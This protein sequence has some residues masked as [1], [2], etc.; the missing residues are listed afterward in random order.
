VFGSLGDLA[1]LMQ[2]AK[3]LGGKLGTLADE[4]REQRVE[5]TAG[6]GLVTVVMNGAQEV[7]A[8]RIDPAAWDTG[9]RELVE[10]LVR[11]ATNQ[12]IGRAKQLHAEG[13]KQLTFG[14]NVPGLD[15]ALGK[16]SGK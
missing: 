6:G 11:A 3:Q 15:D 8:C 14:M 9:D 12:A 7:M 10:D 2:Q 16:L 4:L 13:L 1:N 5:G